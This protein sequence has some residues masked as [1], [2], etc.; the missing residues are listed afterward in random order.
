MAICAA[1]AAAQA[2]AL[3]AQRPNVIIILSD[4]Q[5]YGDFSC[6]G[7]PVLKTPAL[8]KLHDESVRF[9][10]FHVAPQCTPTRGELLTG[11]D[12]LRNKAS[13]VGAGRGIPRRDRAS[14]AEVFKANGY[15]TGIFGKWHLGDG[16][17]DRP[18][19]RG[20]E[21]C[22]WFRGWGLLSEAEY[23]NDY[24]RTRYLDGLQAVQSEKY[25]TDLWFDEA[26]EWMGERAQKKEPFFLYLPLNAVH[27]PFYAP[28]EDFK[29]YH[30]QGLE[31]SVAAFFGMIRNLDKNMARLDDWLAA[32]RL[33]EN[34]I[35]VFMNDNGG[36]GGVEVYN[37]GMKGKKGSNYDGGHRAAC[38]IRW[39]AGFGA[40]RTIH[41]AAEIQDLLPS[42]IDV[43]GL[44][45]KRKQSFDGV[46]LRPVLLEGRPLPDRMFVVQFGN[47]KQ[48]DKYFGSVIWNHWRLV[49]KDELY[50]LGEDPGQEHDVAGQHPEIFQKLRDFYEDWWDQVEPE[51][52]ELVPVLIGSE[53]ENP[54][55]LFA[56]DWTEEYVN[57]QWAVAQAKGEANGGRWQIRAERSGKYLLELSRWPFHLN[58]ELTLAGPAEAVGGT[59][60]R[61]GKG[62][63]IAEGC[64]S[65]NG[66]A[67][68]RAVSRP[69]ATSIAL[70]IPI[71]AGA[72]TL[73]A[74]FKDRQGRDV[75]GAYY[76]RVTRLKR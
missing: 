52:R 11:L 65:L 30:D 21:K 17:P 4:D 46:S 33:K 5:G 40:P 24:Y 13:S 59:G 22:V 12:A 43:L 58:R 71:A 68:A 8:D 48:P 67:P 34:T 49:G 2:N 47:N 60:L 54:V 76:V 66:G 72:N 57:T 75:C 62:L 19:D 16:Y 53:R 32:H 18:M 56:N 14:M 70:E 41:D 9:A 7:N 38:F 51:T 23:D 3:A 20:F 39:P 45:L 35:V 6:H 50:N 26:M 29:F 36:T 42:F 73:R 74:W 1:L 31:K 61:A 27:G 37:A 69:G 64:V 25:C 63:D 28:P 10:N 44:K 55:V 15:R